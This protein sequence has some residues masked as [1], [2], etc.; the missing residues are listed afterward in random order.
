[1]SPDSGP[2]PN[3][4]EPPKSTATGD[5][6]AETEGEPRPTDQAER[7]DI[8]ADSDGEEFSLVDPLCYAPLLLVGAFLVVFPEPLTSVVGVAL[9]TAGLVIAVL[10]LLSVA[11]S[12]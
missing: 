11:E 3:S 2:R 4:D 12:D 8:F 9:I 10:D 5:M 1:M 7:D 6:A